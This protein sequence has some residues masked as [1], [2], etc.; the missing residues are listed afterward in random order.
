MLFD[1]TLGELEAVGMEPERF[2]RD[3]HASEWAEE[4]IM[5]EYE[6][7][8]SQTGKSINYLRVIV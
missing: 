4:N 7:K 5:T 2:T 6:E 1:F 3:L 8:F